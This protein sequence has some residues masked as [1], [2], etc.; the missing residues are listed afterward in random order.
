MSAKGG[1]AVQIAEEDSSATSLARTASKG[2]GYLREQRQG[3]QEL[4]HQ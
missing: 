3:G 4:V 1:E 2:A